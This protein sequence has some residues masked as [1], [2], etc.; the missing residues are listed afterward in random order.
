MS[1][2]LLPKAVVERCASICHPLGI[3]AD[4]PPRVV[5]ED[6]AFR[7]MCAYLEAYRERGLR[8]SGDIEMLLSTVQGDPATSGD[9]ADAV[10]KAVA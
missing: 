6:I 10:R 8:S 7:A 1:S 9:W 4:Q 3:T 5:D 2:R